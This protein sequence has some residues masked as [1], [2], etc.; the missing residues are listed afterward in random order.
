MNRCIEC[1]NLIGRNSTKYCSNQCQSNY[2]YK[3]FIKNWLSGNIDGGTSNNVSSHIKRYLREKNNDS[4]QKC[5]WNEINIYTGS[6]PLEVDH[7][8]GNYKNN[9]K[10]NLR[11]LCPN[12][13]SLTSTYK[14]L[15]KGNGRSFRNNASLT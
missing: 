15:N 9:S 12:C 13:H 3:Q 1:K 5:K 6:V 11:L 14:A 10:D 4:C 2:Q 7:I 8:D